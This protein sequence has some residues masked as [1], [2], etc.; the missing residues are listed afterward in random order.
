[1]K[2]LVSII[3]V[4]EKV[5]IETWPKANGNQQQLAVYISISVTICNISM[6]I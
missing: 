6:K 1:M 2:I 5:V 3:Y 4:Y